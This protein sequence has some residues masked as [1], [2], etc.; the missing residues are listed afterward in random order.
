LKCTR[1]SDPL[2]LH[3][4]YAGKTKINWHANIY[5][6]I[7]LEFSWIVNIHICITLELLMHNWGSVKIS[8]LLLMINLKPSNPCP[9]GFGNRAREEDIS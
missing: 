6:Q 2:A 5:I 4:A 9:R 1:K 8:E 7:T 3:A